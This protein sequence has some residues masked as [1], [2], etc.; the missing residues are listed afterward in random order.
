MN[1]SALVD[2]G[3]GGALVQRALRLRRA[4]LE[5]LAQFQDSIFA[6]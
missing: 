2:A 3:Q 4:G 1:P 5:L 6:V